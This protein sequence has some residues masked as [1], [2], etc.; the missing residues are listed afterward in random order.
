MHTPLRITFHEVDPSP[1]VE[2]R[3]RDEVEKLERFH[4]GLIGCHVPVTTPHRHHRHGFIYGVRID[5]RVPGQE[6]AISR[7]PE[8]NHA[9]EDPFVAIRDAFAAARRKLE[10]HARRV[11]G[12]VK[13]HEPV[14]HGHVIRL[15]PEERYGFLETPDGLQVYFHEHALVRAE[16]ADLRLGD[17]VRFVI[18]EG[19]GEH[20][21]QASTV[22][23]LHHAP[24]RTTES[25]VERGG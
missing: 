4:P 17:D 9:H 11:R 16:L 1:A 23:L 3:L 8:L 22:T 13:T 5:L 12:D 18:A 10:D 24:R 19:E 21:P 25:D 14:E 15:V 6:I 2:S 20:G 7:E